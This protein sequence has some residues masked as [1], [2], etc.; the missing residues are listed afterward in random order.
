[1]SFAALALSEND[2]C[3]V[4][5]IYIIKFPGPQESSVVKYAR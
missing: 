5:T 3:E 4:G 2:H 1:M